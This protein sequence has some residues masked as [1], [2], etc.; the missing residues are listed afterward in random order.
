MST[1]ST[2]VTWFHSFQ[3]IDEKDQ[4]IIQY[5]WCHM[6]KVPVGKNGRVFTHCV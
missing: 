1:H 6:E 2:C 5:D 3:K 4:K